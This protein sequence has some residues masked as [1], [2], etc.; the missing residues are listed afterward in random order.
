MG[1]CDMSNVDDLRSRYGDVFQT[2]NR[3]A[4]SHLWTTYILSRA[5]DCDS[6]TLDTLFRGFCPISGSPLPDDP[7]TQ[8]SMTL[9]RVDGGKAHGITHHCCWPCV[10][11]MQESVLVD[12][13]TI[14]TASG[15]ERRSVL[16]IGDPCA[17]VNTSLLERSYT[18]PFSG[19]RESLSMSAPEV[20]CQDK[21]LVGATFSDHGYPIIG[22]FFNSQAAAPGTTP[23]SSHMFDS[24]CDARKREGYNSGM[25]LIFHKVA[26]INP[27][28]AA[29]I[30]MAA[31][32]D[33]V[34]SDMPQEV[35]QTYRDSIQSWN[36]P[37]ALVCA[38]AM[39]VCVVVQ[40][41]RLVGPVHEYAEKVQRTIEL[42]SLGYSAVGQ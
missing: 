39:M 32:P 13:A 19:Q 24:Q 40:G 16:V 15:S 37:V 18:D 35:N 6:D 21:S 2:G 26:S 34:M 1:A 30:S 3:N 11:D 14:S 42:G 28:V 5:S 12:T 38:A 36:L 31:L 10:C 27:I 33:G 41:R 8:C 20:K 23:T 22:M 17:T 7:R 4:A 25:G 9:P 29:S